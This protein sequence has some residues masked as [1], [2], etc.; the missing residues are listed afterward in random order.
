M[1]FHC[2]TEII[3]GHPVI[4]KTHEALIV[5]TCAHEA[6]SSARLGNLLPYHKHE[7]GFGVYATLGDCSSFYP[8]SAYR[9][10]KE[11][12]G[13]SSEVLRKSPAVT[14]LNP[15]PNQ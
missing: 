8:K 3:L 10:K 2:H 1:K 5:S 12:T 9:D 14:C 15:K 11:P 6:P 4:G 13:E 7:K